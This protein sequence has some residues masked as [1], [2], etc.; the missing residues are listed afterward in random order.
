[1]DVSVALFLVATLCPFGIK[2]QGAPEDYVKC[3]QAMI[4]V[5]DKAAARAVTRIVEANANTAIDRPWP[6]APLVM[7]VAWSRKAPA[8][9]IWSR[10]DLFGRIPG[11]QKVIPLD[12]G[13]VPRKPLVPRKKQR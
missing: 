3:R 5:E 6:D 11:V 4:S 8:V 12:P 2:V 7:V 13:R 9:Q 1:M 10:L